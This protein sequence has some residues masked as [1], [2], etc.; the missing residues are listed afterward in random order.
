MRTTSRCR[1]RDR[2]NRGGDEDIYV[3]LATPSDAAKRQVEEYGSAPARRR[4]APRRQ[5]A[6]GRTRGRP[7]G[8]SQSF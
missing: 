1:A 8:C 2:E 4:Q 6:C 7:G 5:G 3:A